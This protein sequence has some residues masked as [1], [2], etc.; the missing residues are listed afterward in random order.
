MCDLPIKIGI[1][2]DLL[3]LYGN[4]KR[5]C[6]IVTI[7]T[8]EYV[9]TTILQKVEKLLENLSHNQCQSIGFLEL[10]ELQN[11]CLRFLIFFGK[12]RHREIPIGWFK[13]RY[14]VEAWIKN[15]VT[16]RVRHLEINNFFPIAFLTL[17][18]WLVSH[19]LIFGW[20]KKMQRSLCHVSNV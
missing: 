6:T 4:F 16:R 19:Y 17:P 3:N 11:I 14:V 12:L 18:L 8:Q 5:S 1:V 20:L 13:E 15:D 2:Q 7:P 10:G 9:G